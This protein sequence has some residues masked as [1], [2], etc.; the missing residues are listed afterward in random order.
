MN[1][2]V[3]WVHLIFVVFYHATGADGDIH[4]MLR[5][6]DEEENDP[7]IS[8]SEK[9]KLDEYRT[10]LIKQ[11]ILKMLGLERPPNI[12]HSPQVPKQTLDMVVRQTDGKR[13]HADTKVGAAKQVI[14]IA[15]QGGMIFICLHLISIFVNFIG[16]Y[17]NT[18][19]KLSL[20]WIRVHVY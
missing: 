18:I 16:F 9:E 20:S 3:V 19:I 6:L 4:S 2:K 8:E 17:N 13:V 7:R 15:E 12:S 14:V 1:M 10:L 11:E 5:Q